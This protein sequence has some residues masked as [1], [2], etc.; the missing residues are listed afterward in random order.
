MIIVPAVTP[1]PETVAP[2]TTKPLVTAVTVIAVVV[3]EPVTTAVAAFAVKVQLLIVLLSLPENNPAPKYT[4]PPIVERLA[5]LISK[6]LK[7]LLLASLENIMAFAPPVEVPVKAIADT[8]LELLL[9][10]YVPAPPV[11]VPYPVIT[12]P[13]ITPVPESVWPIKNGPDPAVNVPTVN[14]DPVIEEPVAV[15]VAVAPPGAKLAIVIAEVVPIWFTRP[16]IVNFA[17]LFKSKIEDDVALEIVSGV[18]TVV[19][20][21]LIVKPAPAPPVGPTIGNVSGVTG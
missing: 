3:W 7:I 15:V 20:Y 19:G 16:S 1:V 8:L 9:S 6:Y 13:A 12:V 5:L 14:V 21:T 2:G 11:P 10:V 17:V 4:E 18:A